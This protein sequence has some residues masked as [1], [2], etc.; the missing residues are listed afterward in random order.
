MTRNSVESITQDFLTGYGVLPLFG[1][2][3]TGCGIG[4]NNGIRDTGER[5][6]ECGITTH[7][8]LLSYSRD[9]GSDRYTAEFGK[10]PN[11]LTDMGIYRFSGSGIHKNLGTG[12]GI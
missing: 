9:L 4:K 10:T 1:K 11:F 12:F 7:P 3:G 2:R 8:Q 5:W 6:S